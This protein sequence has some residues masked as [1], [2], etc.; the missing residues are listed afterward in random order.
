MVGADDSFDDINEEELDSLCG[1]NV[2][3]IVHETVIRKSMPVQKDLT[4]RT[5]EGQKSI[6][7]EIRQEVTFGP[8]HHK[9][10]QDALG[11]YVYPT[12]FEVREYQ[13]DIVRKALFQ[14]TLCAIPTGMG[15]TFIA[16][17]VMLN[18]FRWSQ[19]GKII[20]T[21]PTRPLVAQQ[22]KA[23]L[24]ITGIPQDQTAI[25]LD[26]SRKNREEIWEEKRVFFTTPQ[27]VE[28]DLKRGVLHPKDIITI[29]IDEAHRATGSY[30]Y[31][32]IIKF[33]SRFNTSYRVLALTATPGTDLIGVQEVVNNLEISKIEA[34]TEESADIVRYMRKKSRAKIEVSPTV[35]IED[36]IEQ[37]GIAILPVLSQAIELKIYEDCNPS[38]INAF[39]AMQQSQ[40][41]IAN[42]GIPEGIKWRNFFILQLLNHVG[43]M[44]KRIKIYGIRTF[45][46]Y[47]ID[48]HKE[49]TTKYSLGK[50]TNKTA[51]ELYYNPILTTMMKQ[52][53]SLLSNPKFLGHG[54]L[55]HVREELADFF[56]DIGSNSRVIIFTELRES[57]L[58]IV[59]CVDTMN[60]PGHPYQVRPHIFIGQA[61]GKEGFD[62]VTF[63]RKNQPKGRKKADR[64]KRLE[65]E[66]QLE[67]DR[68]LKKTQAKLERGARRTGSSEEAQLN[69][70]T[71]KQQKEVIMK[72]KNGEYNVLVCTSI[73][74]EGLDIGEV[75]LIICYDTTSSPIKNIQ[76]MG[77]TGRKRDGRIVLLFSSNESLKFEQ[78]MKDYEKLQYLIC[79]NNLQYKKSDRIIPSDINPICREEHINIDE[80]AQVVNEMEDTE[81][82]IRYATQCMLG[83]KP[84]RRER[85]KKGPKKEKQFFMPDNVNTGIVTANTLVK[86]VTSR[87]KEVKSVVL[88][89]ELPSLDPAE[90]SPL[91]GS[92]PVKLEFDD[93][94][95]AF[96]KKSNSER[97]PIC[98]GSTYGTGVQSEPPSPE[99]TSSDTNISLGQKMDDDD[100]WHINPVAN[101]RK[102][103]VEVSTSATTKK[104]KREPT[105]NSNSNSNSDSQTDDDGLLTIQEREYFLRKYSAAHTVSIDTMPNFKRYTK[106]VNIPHSYHNQKIQRL[107]EDLRHNKKSRTIEMNRTKCI[108]RGL[109]SGIV[110]GDAQLT[111]VIVENDEISYIAKTRK[112]QSSQENS[113]ISRTSS[114][115][116]DELLNSDSDF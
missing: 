28:N 103:K 21:A 66:K 111:S 60:E 40:K 2:N 87:K 110:N 48:K 49:F 77:R 26:K 41:I 69:G 88:D 59:K 109:Q 34:R 32:N 12:N 116:L 37:I 52:C 84:K 114:K 51:A 3:R 76:R 38:Q 72:F 5:I 43:Q 71:Q 63:A 24:G 90:L 45:Y 8:T 15:K 104:P 1:N 57:A 10:V 112:K 105:Q 96:G 11:H 115:E 54:K 94:Y 93:D 4:G 81:E 89:K 18:F 108:A 44:L 78:A 53:E 29:V 14:N 64:L 68:K 39:K 42:P 91:E 65:E 17:T 83:K 82:V 86:K 70:M 7:E 50:S 106:I 73:G 23:C 36:I 16:S 98:G 100:R 30:A 31:T 102:L 99:K 85:K 92:S 107:F 46:N 33:V 79:Q 80:D 47:F 27:V 19:S 58:E 56:S 62:E 113:G 55:N 95:S 101:K 25:L 6:Y 97:L 13:F 74:E 75:D 9:L 20:F 61:K 22:I 35:E 67:E